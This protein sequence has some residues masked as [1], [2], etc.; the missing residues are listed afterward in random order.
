MREAMRR[1]LR[2]DQGG[3]DPAPGFSYAVH[4]TKEAG[5]WD[6]AKRAAVKRALEGL[7]ADPAFEPTEFERRYTIVS[8]DDRPHAGGSLLA[9]HKVL[10]AFGD[11]APPGEEGPEAEPVSQA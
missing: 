11:Q 10:Q 4:W 2:R 8:V 5:A 6:R 3:D 7:I 9:L 1:L